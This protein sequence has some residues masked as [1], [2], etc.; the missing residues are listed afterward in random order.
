MPGSALQLSKFESCRH[1]A[2]WQLGE[3][4][5]LA[6]IPS[7]PS[8][9]A[10]CVFQYPSF[11]SLRKLRYS[12]FTSPETDALG[13]CNCSILRSHSLCTRNTCCPNHYPAALRHWSAF[14]VVGSGS[15]PLVYEV[16]VRRVCARLVFCP[17]HPA[18]LTPQTEERRGM[19]DGVIGMVANT[20]FCSPVLCV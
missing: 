20:L 19:S 5:S 15:A 8:I 18:A 2:Y 9:C 14:I 4:F 10:F 17:V 13:K 16:S 1:N 11:N 12:T 6:P 7:C 3:N